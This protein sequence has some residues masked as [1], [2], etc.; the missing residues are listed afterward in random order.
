MVVVSHT[1][2][3]FM[4]FEPIMSLV[5]YKVTKKY[6]FFFF[7][8]CIMISMQCIEA[9]VKSFKWKGNSKKK[10]TYYVTKWRRKKKL[11]TNTQFTVCRLFDC[12]VYFFFFPLILF[13]SFA[14]RGRWYY[15]EYF[16][17]PLSHFGMIWNEM[18]NT[19]YQI[20]G[21]RRKKKLPKNRLDEDWR[22]KKMTKSE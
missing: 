14:F 19:W 22:K 18:R 3:L 21:E 5:P 1:H 12:R 11:C 17:I 6:F 7:I 8:S 4:D 15:A 20:E 9:Q 10:T 16:I 2:Q 13:I